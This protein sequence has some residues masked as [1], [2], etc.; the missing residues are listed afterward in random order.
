MIYWH[1]K[2][3]NNL[4]RNLKTARPIIDSK[5]KVKNQRINQ[6][7]RKNSRNN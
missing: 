4:L 1:I 5:L 2:Q 7:E 6:I 3:P